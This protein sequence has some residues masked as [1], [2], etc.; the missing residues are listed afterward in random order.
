MGF[1]DEKLIPEIFQNICHKVMAKVHSE[2]SQTSKKEL[3]PKTVIDWK[4][5]TI[6]QK[7]FNLRCLARFWLHP[8]LMPEIVLTVS[9][10][11]HQLKSYILWRSDSFSQGTNATQQNWWNKVLHAFLSVSLVANILKMAQSN[12]LDTMVS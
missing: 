4:M 8:R 12:K 3:L 10:L 7:T 6:F 1:S 9:R 2:P 5:L 11:P